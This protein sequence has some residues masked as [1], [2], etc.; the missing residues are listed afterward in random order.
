MQHAHSHSLGHAHTHTYTHRRYTWIIKYSYSNKK[1]GKIDLLWEVWAS[2][3]TGRYV[4]DG[5][6]LHCSPSHA[7][8]RLCSM[9]YRSFWRFMCKRI[10]EHLYLGISS[11]WWE[12][13]RIL[14]TCV[15]IARPTHLIKA[16]VKTCSILHLLCDWQHEMDMV[17]RSK[18]RCTCSVVQSVKV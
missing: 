1:T 14:N 6:L 13:L 8:G 3:R 5:E 17:G 12:T 10:Y 9:E 15:T 11:Y 18:K 4:W 7:Y 16:D 2:I